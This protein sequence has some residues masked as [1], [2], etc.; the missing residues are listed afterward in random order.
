MNRVLLSVAAIGALTIAAP[1]L[2]Q[3]GYGP[4]R[5]AP[6]VGAWQN[7]N[8]R[9]AQLDRRI[10]MG[11]RNGTLTRGEATRLRAEFQTIANLESRYRMNGLDWR[12]RQ[13]LDRRFDELS[14]RIRYERAD[15]QG[16]GPGYGQGQGYRQGQ[17]YGQGQG[18]NARQAQLE[19]R[20]NFA[21]RNGSLTRREAAILTTQFNDIAALEARYRATGGLQPRERQDLDRRFSIL[22]SRLRV[23]LADNN[24]RWEPYR[25]Q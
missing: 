24:F 18:L 25:Y 15:N 23:E 3:S 4:Q 14:A 16:R 10:D 21:I 5:A 13:D 9:Q 12:E 11:I 22:E 19:R 6:G 17:G 20:I 2:A 8:A 1:A 7:I